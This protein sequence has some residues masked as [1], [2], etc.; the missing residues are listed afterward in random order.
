MVATTVHL[1]RH[2]EVHNPDHILYGRAPGYRLSA[3]GETMAEAAATHLAGGDGL[4]RRDI[5]ALFAS[6]LKRA[7]QTAAPIARE[8]GLDI[9][10]ENRAIEAGSVFE[11]NTISA[12]F[13]LRPAN[14]RHLWNPLR[15]SWGEPYA[16]IAAR[17]RASIDR[18]RR[19]AA[20]H[21]AVIVSHQLP[22]WIARL[23]AERRHF[24]HDPRRR[25]CG[26]GSVTSLHFEDDDVAYVAYAE[27]LLP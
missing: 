26:L 11:G 19:A 8:F 4:R 23:D 24:A 7:Q 2:G 14:L 21:E 5:V 17:M 13:L 6:P 20:G 15:P 10:P 9:V 18:A 3:L 25:Q 12:R 22:I 16:R 27:P 1:V